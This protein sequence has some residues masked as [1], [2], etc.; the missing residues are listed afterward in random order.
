MGSAKA[1]DFWVAA[2][3]SVFASLAFYRW[4]ALNERG[5]VEV[6]R[7]PELHGGLQLMRL[8]RYYSSKA[9]CVLMYS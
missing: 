8:P 3:V 1:R 4:L 6:L 2:G 7:L 9:R 5:E